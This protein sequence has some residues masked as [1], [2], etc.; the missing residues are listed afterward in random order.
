MLMLVTVDNSVQLFLGWT[1]LGKV[2]DNHC[3][4]NNTKLTHLKGENEFGMHA[5]IF[6]TQFNLVTK[7]IRTLHIWRLKRFGYCNNDD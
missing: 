2:Y 3:L 6:I 7:M 4:L 5:S 1:L